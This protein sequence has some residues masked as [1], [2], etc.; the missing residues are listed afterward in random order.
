MYCYDNPF[1]KA[2]KKLKDALQFDE[3]KQQKQDKEK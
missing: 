2:I 3:K 1:R